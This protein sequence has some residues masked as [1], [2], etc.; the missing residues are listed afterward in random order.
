MDRNL[1]VSASLEYIED[2]L[3]SDIRLEDLARKVHLSKYHYHRLFHKMTG[4]SVTKYITRL[5]MK[6]AGEDLIKTDQPIIDIALKYQYSSQEAFSRAFGRIYG[7]TPGRYRKTYG[8]GRVSN[9]M[10]FGP[11]STSIT[12]KAA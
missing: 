7:T 6:N 8:H 5:R 3:D 4:E 1:K 2:N 10:K 9:I 12:S 11:Y